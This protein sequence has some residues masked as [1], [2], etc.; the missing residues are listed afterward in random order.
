MY[1]GTTRASSTL[2]WLP[3]RHSLSA[4]G[5][6][7]AP[8]LLSED[9][10]MTK[11]H[12]Y[13]NPVLKSLA[14][15]L[16][17]GAAAVAAQAQEAASSPKV[18]ATGK[19]PTGYEVTFHFAAPD[20]KRVQIKGEWSFARQSELGDAAGTPPAVETRGILPSDWQPGDFPIA[21]PNATAPNFPIND[22]TLEDDGSWSFTTPLPSGIFTYAFYVDCPAGDLKDCK[23]LSDPA[24]AP[25]NEEDGK[26]QGSAAGGSQVYVPSDPAFHTVDYSWQAPATAR[27][28]LEHVTY[29]SAGHENPADENYLAV[30][31]PPGYDAARAEPYPTLYL[32]HGGGG[33]EVQWSTQGGLRDIMDN[34]IA[35][36]EAP[37]MVVVM[38]NAATTSPHV[39]FFRAFDTELIEQVI[40][41]VEANYHV[42]TQASD[43]AF[44]GLS[45]GGMIT[46]SLMLQYPDQFGYFGMMSAGI[47]PAYAD[48][49]DEQVAGLKGKSIMIAG[50]WQDP[51]NAGFMDF[52]EGPGR[53][54]TSLLEAG[55]PSTWYFVNGGH[56][57]YVW[58]LLLKHF[59]TSVAFEPVP[60]IE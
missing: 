59:V 15:L 26:V 16:L 4:S 12:A 52:H 51:I 39:D 9:S 17:L 25:W 11:M 7:K 23:P 46:N 41:Y 3:E 31:T 50:S 2:I 45:M 57:W 29:P 53:E 6:D 10:R 8:D 18:T 47:P 19:G 60:Y 34:L 54:L 21:Y 38:P 20:A 24:N 49:T 40:P 55:V 14:T 36:G 30:Y 27:G 43:R 32:M 5:A 58:R 33:N 35:S 37:A 1:L 22:M 28:E 56:E 42:S 13:E 48:L 44:S